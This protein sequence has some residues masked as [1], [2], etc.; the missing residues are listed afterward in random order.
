MEQL[1]LKELEIFTDFILNQRAKCKR[2]GKGNKKL[3][4]KLLFGV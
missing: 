3:I 2:L 4:F 1:A